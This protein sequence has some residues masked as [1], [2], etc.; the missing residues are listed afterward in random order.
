MPEDLRLDE[1]TPRSELVVAEHHV[2]RARFRAIDAHNHLPV[3]DQ[4][5]ASLVDWPRMVADLDAVNVE[6][7]VNLSGGWGETLRA[8]LTQLDQAYPGRFYTFCNLDFRQALTPGWLDATLRQLRDD[9]AAGARGL[10]IFKRLGLAHRDPD[11]AL[12]MPDDP[13]LFAIWELVGELDVPVLIHTADPTA[14]FRPLDGHN[15]RWDELNAHPDWHFHGR[16]Y[17]SF[18]TLIGSLYRLIAA[19]PNTDFIT[20]HVGCYAENLAFVGEMLDRYPNFY[21]DMSARIAELGRAPYTAREF[22]IRHPDRVLFGTDF[23]P[24]P[25]MY[26]VHWRFFETDDQYFPYDPQPEEET[27]AG[28]GGIPF[29]NSDGL[30]VDFTGQWS[31][32]PTQGR[33]RICGL[34]LPDEV[35]EKVY[36]RNAARLLRLGLE[37]G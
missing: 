5:V 1:Y 20:A 25:N 14:F 3:T 35:L 10:K 9:V 23:R 37:E 4:R 34:F 19:H 17:P 7:V 8:N 36:Y 31:P 15:E 27:V 11:G 33:W 29:E 12:I 21:T 22:F 13:R 30:S 28:E 16:G 6:S 2:E 24:R 26:R 32:I 18:E